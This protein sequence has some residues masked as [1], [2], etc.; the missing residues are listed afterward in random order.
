MVTNRSGGCVI[1][2][3]NIVSQP[4]ESVIV[5]VYVPGIRFVAEDVVE[6][7][8][9]AH[10]YAYP[11][12][13]PPV[14]VR[15]ILPSFAPLQLTFCL[16]IFGCMGVGFFTVSWSLVRQPLPSVTVHI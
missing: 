16:L 8:G 7:A 2:T 11:P 14:G 9:A 10:V 6:T 12:A 1:F 15:V 4:F 5:M 3:V 13:F